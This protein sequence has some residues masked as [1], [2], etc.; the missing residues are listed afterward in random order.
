MLACPSSSSSPPPHLFPLS[1]FSLTLKKKKHAFPQLHHLLNH[2]AEVNQRDGRG[3]TPLHRAAH[4]AHYDGYLEV[5]DYL[6]SRGA[7]PNVKTRNFDPYLDPGRKTALDVCVDDEAIRGR[8]R[9]LI[10]RHA[11]AERRPV[12]HRDIGCWWTLYDFGLETV[13]SWGAD[14]RHP[15]PET[16]ARAKDREERRARREARRAKQ[17]LPPKQKKEGGAAKKA[18]SVSATAAATTS[19]SS[20][21]PSSPPPSPSPAPSP[22]SSSS[23]SSSSSAFRPSSFSSPQSGTAVL[24]PGQG[25]QAVG[26]LSSRVASLPAV[27]RM[28]RT[29]NELLGFDLGLLMREGPKERLDDTA[30]A[31]PALFVAG[32][33]AVERARAEARERGGGSSSALDVDAASA[34]A[35][36]SLGEYCALVFAGAL[37][38]EDGL[39]VVKARGEAMSEASRVPESQRERRHGMLTVVGL[40]DAGAAAAAAAG[41]AAAEAAAPPAPDDPVCEVANRLFPTGRVLS[42]HVLALEAAAEH[43]TRAGAVRAAMLPVAGAFH[44]RLMRPAAKAL[45]AA[46]AAAELRPPRIPVYSNVTG[47]PFPFERSVQEV[48]ELLARQL[49]EPVLWQETLEAVSAAS[50]SSSPPSSA[51]AVV[52]AGPGGGQI[53]SMMKRVDGAVWKRMAVVSPA[54]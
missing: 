18:I 2:G 49:V 33:A 32:L 24:F 6:L 16:V 5:C 35:G 3:W 13:R 29:A 1:P 15:Y 19:S 40:D 41:R 22:P 26:M 12:P 42:G 7:D 10:E 21:F 14:H 46:L 51:A 37:S 8:L 39:R 9:E 38:F 30:V 48:K 11:G 28:L 25:A 36:L 44:T 53:R 20:S 52:E 34:A 31:Q 50:S 23:S 4:L 45:R 54:E 43:A 17:G 47:R 27:A